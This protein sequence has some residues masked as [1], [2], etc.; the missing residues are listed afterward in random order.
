M[1]VGD[2]WEDAGW[3]FLEPGVEVEGRH[4]CVVTLLSL[5]PPVFGLKR[6]GVAAP[7]SAQEK[8]S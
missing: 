7:T 8:P 4:P 2:D 3:R 5:G 6:G 1:E